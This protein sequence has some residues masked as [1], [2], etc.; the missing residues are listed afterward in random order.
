[1]SDYVE[2]NDI[3]LSGKNAFRSWKKNDITNQTYNLSCN[4][5][6]EEND[7]RKVKDSNKNNSTISL[8]IAAYENSVEA[9]NIKFNRS[10]KT[11][12]DKLNRARKNVQPMFPGVS[13]VIQNP[14]EFPRQQDGNQRN[15]SEGMQ[16]RASQTLLNPNKSNKNKTPADAANT[17][18]E[19][20]CHCLNTGNSR[21]FDNLVTHIHIYSLFSLQDLKHWSNYLKT[22]F[23]NCETT[24]VISGFLEKITTNFHNC[25]FFGDLSMNIQDA[26]KDCQNGNFKL[27]L[28]ICIKANI[29]KFDRDHYSSQLEKEMFKHDDAK[30]LF[31][32]KQQQN[33]ERS[34]MFLKC[35]HLS[36][37]LLFLQSN[38]SI[39]SDSNEDVWYS[40][41]KAWISD[42]LQR[43]DTSDSAIASISE[44]LM[45]NYDNERHFMNIDAKILQYFFE[46]LPS[47]TTVNEIEKFL[48]D[49]SSSEFPLDF[50]KYI[51]EDQFRYSIAKKHKRLT[52]EILFLSLSK[53]NSLSKNI[54]MSNI[55]EMRPFLTKL[56]KSWKIREIESLM[57]LMNTEE[58]VPYM[59]ECLDL[60]VQWRATYNLCLINDLK[61]IPSLEWSKKVHQTFV[62]HYM[63]DEPHEYTLN[64]L[65]DIIFEQQGIDMPKEKFIKIYNE[66][67]SEYNS[68]SNK[69]MDQMRLVVEEMPA[70]FSKRLAYIIHISNLHFGF[71]IRIAQVLPIILAHLKPPNSS[72]ILQVNT[73]EG[74]TNIFAI[75]AVLKALD[76]HKV[77]IITS[78]TELADEQSEKMA[79]FFGIFGLTTGNNKDTTI[80]PVANY[81]LSFE[82]IAVDGINKLC[83]IFGLT[84]G[85]NK[86]PGKNSSNPYEADIVYGEINNFK[87]HEL[88]KRFEKSGIKYGRNC[89]FALIDEADLVMIDRYLNTT[90]LGDEMP[91]MFHVLPIL[92]AIWAQ[93]E[94]I[95]STITKE[96]GKYYKKNTDNVEE[97]IQINNIEEYYF[98][99]ISNYIKKVLRIYEPMEV[100]H[101]IK[102]PNDLKDYINNEIDRWI[103]YAVLAKLEMRL[104]HEYTLKDGKII[105]VDALNTG[106]LQYSTQMSHGLHQFLQMKHGCAV[107]P[108]SLTTN[109]ISH[110]EFI[111]S[112][113]TN[114]IPLTGTAGDE[115][116]K[117]FL[118]ETYNTD[119]IVI[120]PYRKSKL[121]EL[122]SIMCYSKEDW[123]DTIVSDNLKKMKNGQAVVIIVKYI[124]EAEYITNKMKENGGKVFKY[125]NDEELKNALKILE[126]GDCIVTTN[127]GARG[128][129]FCPNE[130]VIKN[131]GLHVCSTSPA[132]ND[133][134]EHQK[135]GRT[136]RGGNPGTKICIFFVGD[137][138]EQ[139]LRNIMN[140]SVEQ[141]KERVKIIK[142]DNDI[143]KR[144]CDLKVKMETGKKDKNNEI[145]QRSLNFKFGFWLHENKDKLSTEKFEKFER[146]CL[147]NPGEAIIENSFVMIEMAEAAIEKNELE[148]ANSYL[149]K[150]IN[151]DPGFLANAYY[152]RGYVKILLYNNDTKKYPL[153]NAIEDFKKAREII[154][155]RHYPCLNFMNFEQFG[156]SVP[157][158]DQ[159]RKLKLLYQRIIFFI[160]AAIGKDVQKIIKLLEN[161]SK[162]G[163]KVKIEKLDF[164]DALPPE[165]RKDLYK[166]EIQMFQTNGFRN[167]FTFGEKIPINL[168]DVFGLGALASAQVAAG[169]SA[170]LYSAGAGFQ[171]G[172]SLIRQGLCDAITLIKDVIINRNF[173]W[174][175]WAWQKVISIAFDLVCAGWNSV[176]S[177]T[178]GIF[179]GA[180]T[181]INFTQAGVNTTAYEALKIDSKLIKKEFLIG[182]S[183]EICASA[184][185]SSLTNTI[186]GRF[187]ELVTDIV[188]TLSSKCVEN[189]PNIK[190][191]IECDRKNRNNKYSKKLEQK[192]LELIELLNRDKGIVFRIGREISSYMEKF[193]DW[194]ELYKFIANYGED[195]T[196]AVFAIYRSYSKY[197]KEISNSEECLLDYN[198]EM[199]QYDNTIAQLKPINITVK[200]FC[201][202]IS[203][204]FSTRI[205]SIFKGVL[206]QEIGS[207]CEKRL[208]KSYSDKTDQE[209]RKFNQKLSGV[210]GD[211]E[212]Y[213]AKLDSGNFATMIE[214][215]NEITLKGGP[216]EAVNTGAVAL[217][218]KRTI[219]VIDGDK[220][221]T[222]GN[223]SEKE[224]IELIYVK[225]P[226]DEVGH[227]ELANEKNVQSSGENNCFYD[228]IAAEIGGDANVLSKEVAEVMTYNFRTFAEIHK[229]THSVE[230]CDGKMNSFEKA[231]IPPNLDERTETGYVYNYFAKTE[232]EKWG[233]N[234]HLSYFC[235]IPDHEGE[236]MQQRTMFYINPDSLSHEFKEIIA[237][238]LKN[239]PL[240]CPF[241]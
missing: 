165:E 203:H 75:L 215:N 184:V 117:R 54:S 95:S 16:F 98:E 2:R 182:V 157:L 103:K 167:V 104:N 37:Y 143:F 56:L 11:K 61:D 135:N 131:G 230:L 195:I 228:V 154:E 58:D 170:V 132:E 1:M 163:N 67:I 70:E 101:E 159:I 176:K 212:E 53:N 120:P 102:Y 93:L 235:E 127:I 187:T 114:I 211:F 23:E 164:K 144:F 236:K 64:E 25:V 66:Y 55:F 62:K 49:Y 34:N 43:F 204:C 124:D 12:Q 45:K 50:L 138:E 105:I 225:N 128:T 72:R 133:R 196:K 180:K 162:N 96:N 87:A 10:E 207:R 209:A 32:L 219:I 31:I 14:F 193:G 217:L 113:G 200:D 40:V 189:D 166:D 136:A 21:E 220:K 112:Y 151:S 46:S 227:Y 85:N 130:A 205:V 109:F 222:F 197:V 121:V 24:D 178:T 140:D 146:E 241:N 129:D 4:N 60:F 107:T 77:D 35:R 238:H 122:E 126:P 94:C 218:K 73:G 210:N 18:F 116:D 221:Y 202:N 134:G 9:Q 168:R 82:E 216:P 173:N 214:E 208:Y 88:I 3:D 141:K 155:N 240:V 179:R 86:D 153:S 83:N 183:R 123:R 5:R 44:E 199:P 74:K 125:S 191:L 7:S 89:D 90:Y 76:K 194:G 20:A 229:K 81:Y 233:E 8:N 239:N 139:R 33:N 147:A 100:F 28:I 42:K 119:C 26:I 48:K 63:S 231:F 223:D 47:S 36:N 190:M 145:I 115:N 171:V 181:A 65:I 30:L 118:R 6:N 158:N 13:C 52:W 201:R 174:K 177:A 39:Q 226:G 152:L 78:S 160:D 149:T 185:D 59:K 51:L 142:N 41:K 29:I 175:T 97:L 192:F 206:V 108:P 111:Q 156:E 213:D 80:N 38:T 224:P 27:L 19:K 161:A 92:G 79:P 110:F 186:E 234:K 237:Q 22:K 84:T 137:V 99:L 106:D 148:R 17:A 198:K 232:T 68:I 69:N 71:K 169:V 188:N 91:G 57:E 150:A 172:Y 15:E